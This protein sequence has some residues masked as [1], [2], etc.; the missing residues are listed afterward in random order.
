MQVNRNRLIS[1][2][3]LVAGDITLHGPRFILI[4]FGLG[5]PAMMLFGLWL[6]L[7]R[8]VFALGL[9]IF[10]V[11]L[12]YLVL[13][14]YAVVIVRKGS[15]E[16]EVNDGLAHGKQYLRQF[17]MQQFLILIPLAILIIAVF[18]EAKK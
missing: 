13:L 4:E 10:L 7:S 6:M 1:V 5:T 8:F 9:Y 14:L 17:G 15:S 18:Q 3:K 16:T 2:R 11:G 12:N